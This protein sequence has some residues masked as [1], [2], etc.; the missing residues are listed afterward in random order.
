MKLSVCVMFGLDVAEAEAAAVATR[1]FA[2]AVCSP[3]A[4]EFGSLALKYVPRPFTAECHRS[5]RVEGWF[6]EGTGQLH[7]PLVHEQALLVPA[8]IFGKSPVVAAS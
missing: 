7:A 2:S 4:S 1:R 8:L 3:R 5:S 6:C